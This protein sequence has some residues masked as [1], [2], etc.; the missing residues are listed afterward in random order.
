MNI[1]AFRLWKER[2][3]VS[4]IMDPMSSSLVQQFLDKTSSSLADQFIHK[5]EPR[6][7]NVK[8][9]EVLLKWEVDQ[10]TRGLVHQHLN[11]VSPD[12]ADEF[13]VKYQPKEIELQWMEVLSKW[14]EE[15]LARG[16]VFKHL[17][18]VAPSLAADFQ[19]KHVLSVKSVPTKLIGLIQRTLP[20][21]AEKDESCPSA[22]KKDKIKRESHNRRSRVNTFTTEELLRIKRAIAMKEDVRAVA[23]EMGRSYRSLYNKIRSDQLTGTRGGKYSAEEE[24]RIRLAVKNNEDYKVVAK[25]LSRAAMSVNAKMQCIANDPYYGMKRAKKSF[26]VEEDLLILD[27][28]VLGLDVTKLSQVETLPSFIVTRVAK[29]I[30][31]SQKSL[32][33]RWEIVILP[34]LLQH[35]TGT[36]GFRVERVLTSLITEKF[37]DTKGIDWWEIVSQ[38]QEFAGHTGLVLEIGFGPPTADFGSI[39]STQKVCKFRLLKKHQKCVFSIL[40]PP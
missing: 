7:I 31:R 33:H 27:E 23:K 11:A 9:E 25:E 36:S 14:K 16:L 13:K 26:S 32:K 5:Y 3:C 29:E 8:Y 35:Y 40:T 1:H 17:K 34:C 37:S 4:I 12:L 15:Q 39:W 21:I 10:L 22:E 2:A 18:K 20:A 6:E 38:H 24:I 28:V 30:G 19:N